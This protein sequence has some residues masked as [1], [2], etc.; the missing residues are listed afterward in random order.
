MP[1]DRRRLF[2][3]L[4]PPAELQTAL[5]CHSRKALR[6][7]GGRPVAAE[8]LHLTLAF[9]GSVDERAQRCMEASAGAVCGE[10]FVLTLD[11]LGYFPG[12]RVIWAG[13]SLVP[14]ALS[15]L[16]QTLTESLRPCGYQPESRPFQ[17]HVTLMRKAGR[18]PRSAELDPA[19]WRVDDFALVE[20]MTLAQGAQYRILR[21]WPLRSAPTPARARNDV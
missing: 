12:A 4:W 19:V 1:V 9:V 18:G 20:S 14:P 10:P 7:G 11:R 16:V 5:G 8:F 2:F 13:A 17:A 21:R 6:A 15:R 3:A